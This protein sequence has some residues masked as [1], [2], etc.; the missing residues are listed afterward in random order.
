MKKWN[1]YIFRKNDIRGI[2]KKDFDLDFAYYL[3]MA[4]AKHAALQKQNQMVAIGHDSRLSSPSITKA[5][6][7]GLKANHTKVRIMGLVPTPLCFAASHFL[8][9]TEASI[10][11]TASHNPS[12]FNG[13]K[14]S[15]RKK[16]I[17]SKELL[18][19]KKLV[20]KLQLKTAKKPNFLTQAKLD[21]DTTHFYTQMMQKKFSHLQ[22]KW[23]H[24]IIIDCGNGAAGPIAEA[25]FKALNLKVK[26]LYAKPDGHFPAHHPD[27]SLEENLQDLKQAVIKNKAK[28]GIALDG[29]GDRLVVLSP[30]AKVLYGDELMALFVSKQKAKPTPYVVADVKCAP[31]FFDFVQAQNK[32]PIMWKSGHSLIRQQTF[33]KNACFGGEFSGHY[34]FCDDNYFLDD[35]IYSSLRLIQILCECKHS[36]IDKLLKQTLTQPGV[37]TQEIRI[38]I[39]KREAKYLQSIK[40]YYSKKSKVRLNQTDGVRVYFPNGTWGLVRFS[41]TQNILTCRFG[42]PNQAA[43]KKIQAK[44]RQLIF[45][46]Q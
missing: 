34:F 23:K 39:K 3:G 9:N 42:G 12:D 16:N 1:P 21:T 4:F 10:M 14:L 26:F 22:K 15:I 35:G 24:K 27:P 28:L 20:L 7:A 13:F 18:K 37:H 43:V 45:C 36:N 19:I 8:P 31:W 30:K 46:P 17:H 32:K 11:V 38:P 25:V 33:K 5:V 41:N 2:F 40:N 6:I 29:D 44:F